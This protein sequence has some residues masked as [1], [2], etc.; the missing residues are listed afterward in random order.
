MDSTSSLLTENTGV[1]GSVLLKE[2]QRRVRPAPLCLNP[3][4]MCCYLGLILGPRICLTLEWRGDLCVLDIRVSAAPLPDWLFE[5]FAPNTTHIIYVREILLALILLM[6]KF[7]QLNPDHTTRQGSLKRS[8]DLS[9]AEAPPTTPPKK[10]IGICPLLKP[11]LDP[12]PPES[13]HF[14]GSPVSTYFLPSWL[15]PLFYK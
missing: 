5:I 9:S 12:L 3:V 7:K 10:E 8:W 6:R 2:W 13:C 15:R 1:H 14:S 4:R 11:S